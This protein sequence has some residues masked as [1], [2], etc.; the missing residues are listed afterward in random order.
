[1]DIFF[2]DTYIGKI[3]IE[4]SEDFI[5]HLYIK[6]DITKSTAHIHESPIIIEAKRQLDDYFNKKLKI[7]SLPLNPSGTP[8]MLTIW[9]LLQEIP[10]GEIITYKELAQKAGNPKAARAV[11]LANNKN[12]IPIIIP[13]HRVIGSNGSLTGFRGG[14]DMKKKLLDLEKN[15]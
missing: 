5:T 3:G 14:L 9:K 11:G 8:F 7:F 13:C 15:N 12:P 4:A 2:Y 1:M 10:Y 6:N